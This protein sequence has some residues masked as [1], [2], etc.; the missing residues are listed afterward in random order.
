[1]ITSNVGKDA[2]QQERLFIAGEDTK[3]YSHFGRQNGNFLQS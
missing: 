2:E 1:M 3:W